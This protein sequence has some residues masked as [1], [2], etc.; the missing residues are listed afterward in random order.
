MT[1]GTSA[2]GLSHFKLSPFTVSPNTSTHSTPGLARMPAAPAVTPPSSGS[3]AT[4]Q[5]NAYTK[6][7]NGSSVGFGTGGAGADYI[8]TGLGYKLALGATGASLTLHGATPDALPDVLRLNLVGANS[9]AKAIEENP[10]SSQIAGA[11]TSQESQAGGVAYG[12]IVYLNVWNGIDISYYGNS[13]KQLEF[14]FTVHPGADASQIQLEYVGGKFLRLDPNGNLLITL[15]DGKVVTQ[16]APVSYQMSGAIRESVSSNF[17]LLGNDQVSILVGA[18]DHQK[19]LIIDPTLNTGSPLSIEVFGASEGSLVSITASA[20]ADG[21]DASFPSSADFTAT[22]DWGDGSESE[23]AITPNSDGT[24]VVMDQHA[25]DEEGSYTVEVTFSDDSSNLLSGSVDATVTD[26]PLTAD[27]VTPLLAVEGTAFTETV[28][29]FTDTDPGASSSIDSYTASIDWGDG[30]PVDTDGSVTVDGGSVSGN[31][32]Y[33]TPGTYDPTVTIYDEVGGESTAVFGSIT[34]D[35]APLTASFGTPPNEVEGT[36]FTETVAIFTDTDPG[37]SSSIDS[38]TA[39]IDWGDGTPVDTDSAV[40]VDGGSVSGNHTYTTPGT[41]NV[42]VTI[43]DEEEYGSY[44]AVFGSIMVDDA[45][46]SA[47]FGTPPNEVEGA[48]FTET[49]AIFTDTDPSASSSVDSYTASIDWGDGTPVDT[50][51]AVTVDG[52]SVSGNHT[53]TTPGTYNV[54]VT[55]YDEEEYGSSTAVFGSITV[56][57]AP[58]NAGDGLYTTVIEGTSLASVQV[59]TFSDSDP[60]A[61]S[62][63]DSYTASVD[64]GDGSS[65]DTYGTVVVDGNSVYG[66]H[67]YENDGV[68]SVVATVYDNETNTSVLV[69]GSVTVDDALLTPVYL[70]AVGQSFTATEGADTGSVELASFTVSDTT[71]TVDNLS[72]SV[73]WGDGLATSVVA[74]GADGYFSV[75]ADHMYADAGSYLVTVSVTDETTNLTQI[76]RATATVGEVPL[77]DIGAEPLEV[78]VGA[79]LPT[80]SI[81]ATFADDDSGSN[82]S[83]FSASIDWGDGTAVDSQAVTAGSSSGEYEVSAEAHAYQ[84]PGTYL[85]HTHTQEESGNSVDSYTTI[86][87]DPLLDGTL[88]LQVAPFYG[89]SATTAS[90]TLATFTGSTSQT[91]GSFT[92][93]VNWGDGSGWDT[94]SISGGGGS[95]SV[96]G[97][98]IYDSFGNYLVLVEVQDGTRSEL[99]GTTAIITTEAPR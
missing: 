21:M 62:S 88:A 57:D 64:W 41:Y 92:A 42:S 23:P 8:A 66:T 83:N 56:D 60:Y 35:D 86:V 93:L 38:Y 45:L 72:V 29:I 84:I 3:T 39:S 61:S 4:S 44:T 87:V 59:A 63:I 65:V 58:L 6:L 30:T 85:V 51:S 9:T 25:Y 98:H 53:Y 2:A 70:D 33:T 10:I 49:V 1:N 81:V 13:Q 94:A 32:T 17:V 50:D 7:A 20:L 82:P 14:D 19:T 48:A 47:S 71:V 12:K 96:D 54:S 69:Y 40:T 99:R 27:I 43:Y 55:I 97:D 89:T 77:A 46:L 15:A 79:P 68:Y 5:P 16:D 52:G 95:F 26:A 78:A 91:P 28:A 90:E 22:I 75:T 34:V 18:Y 11:S 74:E 67:T 76:T 80:S 73:D 36:A 31:H 24:L 37:A